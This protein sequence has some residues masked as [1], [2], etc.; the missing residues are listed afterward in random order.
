MNNLLRLLADGRFHSGEELGAVLGVTRSAVWKHVKRLEGEYGVELFRLPGKGYRLAEPLSLL[1]YDNS[2]AL[3]ARLGWGFYLR[4]TTDSTNAEALRL[5][6]AGSAAPFVV[7]AECQTGG[8]GRRGRTW[9]SPPAQ[10]IYYSLA[11]KIS[12]DPR[13]L[14]GLSLVVGLAILHALRRA[15]VVRA[16]LK[17]PNDIYAHG[18]K[19]AGILLELHGDPADEC[20]VIIGVGVNVNMAL[21]AV[22]IDQ[23]WTSVREQTGFLASRDELT[24]FI[25]ESLFHYLNSHASEGFASLRSE[26]EANDIWRG[27]SCTLSA[28]SQQIKGIVTGVDEQ[29]ALRLWIEGQGERNFSGGELSLRLDH[30]S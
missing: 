28:G 11:L 29:G 23:P 6:R 22:D 15:G 30:D 20:H 8:R 4:D 19:I 14:S 12:D 25:S 21:G 18:K 27:K 9:V 24:R 2:G 16:G 3:L 17:W 1:N 26:W 7:M 13:R 5:I 10:N